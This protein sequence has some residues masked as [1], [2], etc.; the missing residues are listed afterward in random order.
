MTKEIKTMIAREFLTFGQF[1]I[2]FCTLMSFSAPALTTSLKNKTDTYQLLDLFGNAFERIRNDSVEEISDED[3]I[4]AAIEGMLG[5]LDPH[6]NFLNRKKFK[7]MKVQTRGEFGGLGIEVTLDQDTDMIKIVSP[8]DD[9]PAFKAGMKPGDLIFAVEGESIRGL[10]LNEAVEKLRGPIGTKVKIT[11]L[12][13][14][15]D[16]FDLEII[17]DKIKIRSV[18]YEITCDKVWI[19]WI[20]FNT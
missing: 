17:R 19:F 9:T 18:R 10:P 20:I 7:E 13:K 16:P 5:H 15:E 6:S 14:D 4:E 2:I 11:V 1:F 12:R 3:L 8:I